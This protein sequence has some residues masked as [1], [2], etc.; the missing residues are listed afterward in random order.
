MTLSDFQASV[1]LFIRYPFETAPLNDHYR[2]LYV[3]IMVQIIIVV[4][5]TA[6]SGWETVPRYD[7]CLLMSL[8]KCIKKDGP[9]RMA[10]HKL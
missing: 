9:F 7:C 3:S 5:Y 6:V 1:H 2:Y 8:L 10:E 4:I